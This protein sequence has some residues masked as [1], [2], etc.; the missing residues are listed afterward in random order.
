M[1]LPLGLPTY[2]KSPTVT[3]AT[4][5]WDALFFACRGGGQLFFY[6]HYRPEVEM[7]TPE[8]EVKENSVMNSTFLN[9]AGK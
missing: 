2:P 6:V 1:S 4:S 9:L 8:E 3:L 5:I 7:G